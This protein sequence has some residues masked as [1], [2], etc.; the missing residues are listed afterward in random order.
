ML[1][2]VKAK[3]NITLKPRTDNIVHCYS[4]DAR[5]ERVYVVEESEFSNQDKLIAVGRTLISP[6]EGK[7]LGK[8]NI[9]EKAFGK[10]KYIWEKANKI[11]RLLS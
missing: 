3:Q 9:W 6:V 1:I 7:H 8:S 10:K 5:S 11:L 2:K 4:N